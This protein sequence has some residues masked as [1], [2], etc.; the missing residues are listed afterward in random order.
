MSPY[1]FAYK[2]VYG[3]PPTSAVVKMT[4]RVI[5]AL[6]NQFGADETL[7]RFRNYLS[8]TPAKF[9]AAARFAERFVAFKD[10]G[11]GM[12][13]PKAPHGYGANG[14]PIPSPLPGETPDQYAERLAR[15][16]F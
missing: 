3:E 15:L 5:R 8:V 12:R 9:Y 13:D 1:Y 10:G 14:K 4:V 6:E 16:G 7:K 11:D 2:T